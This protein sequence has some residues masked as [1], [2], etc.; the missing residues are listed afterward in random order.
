MFSR[1]GESDYNLVLIDGV[2]VNQ[3]GGIVRLQPH[4]RRRD[5]ARRSGARRAVGAVGIGCDGIGRA[6]L[7][8]ARRRRRCAAAHRRRSKAARSTRCAA[9]RAST[10]A[11]ASVSTITLGASHRRTDGAFDDLLPEDDE[12]EQDAVD[13][14]VG[15]VL[16]RRATLRASVRYT[17][18]RGPIGR[19]DRLRRARHRHRVR[20]QATSRATSSCHARDRL[21]ADRIGDLQRLPLRE[22]VGGHHWRSA[23]WRPTRCSPARRTRCSRTARGWCA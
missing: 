14:G 17:D 19:A 11:R 6:G 1:G 8:Q 15:V 13:G 23:V 21:A 5:R 22:P 20:D 3:S 2:R 7:H 9:T 10:A 18:G 16:G 12:F 4:Q